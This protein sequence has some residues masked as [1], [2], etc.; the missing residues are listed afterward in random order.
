MPRSEA[1]FCDIQPYPARPGIATREAVHDFRATAR[2]IKL[3][4]RSHLSVRLYLYCG[5]WFPAIRQL[6]NCPSPIVARSEL[7]WDWSP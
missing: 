3:A 4:F 6:W 7:D 5:P 2:T 1:G